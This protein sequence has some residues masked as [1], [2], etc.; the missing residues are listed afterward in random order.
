MALYNSIIRVCSLCKTIE[1]DG[2]LL[3][4]E[5]YNKKLLIHSGWH[6]S[7]TFLSSD[8]AKKFF[9]KEFEDIS[10]IFTPGLDNDG[11]R[12]YERCDQYLK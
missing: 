10:D 12:T 3:P 2:K 9:G 6:F 4:P 8:C 7:D 11:K 5:H 1:V